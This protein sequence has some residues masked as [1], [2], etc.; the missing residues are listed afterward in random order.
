MTVMTSVFVIVTV[1]VSAVPVKEVIV[2]VIVILP[3]S[4]ALGTWPSVVT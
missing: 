4:V 3:A 2:D 1:L